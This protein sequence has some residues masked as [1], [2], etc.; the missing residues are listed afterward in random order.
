MRAGMGWVDGTNTCTSAAAG[1]LGCHA[2]GAAVWGA[3]APAGLHGV[4]HEH[5]DRGGEPELGPP[6]CRAVRQRPAAQ[7]ERLRRLRGLPHHHA[8]DEPPERRAGFQRREPHR[9]RDHDLGRR[10]QD[11]RHQHLLPH[12]EQ[13]RLGP[14]VGLPGDD[15]DRRR[16]QRLRRLPRRLGQRLEHRCRP[17]HL[18]RDAEHARRPGDAVRLLRVPRA[19]ERGYTFTFGR[20]PATGAARAST[21]T[22]RSRSTRTRTAADDAILRAPTTA[23]RRQ[24]P[25]SGCHTTEDGSH[26]FPT[27]AGRSR[28]R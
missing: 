6:R 14:Q 15:R 7:P 22:A 2:T 28:R 12:D 21:A 5:D 13:R 27:P 9:D 3:A 10:A 11:L 4:P 16:G 26:N 23:P 19:R 24:Q 17:P 20:R 25:C 8:V 1:D 18:G